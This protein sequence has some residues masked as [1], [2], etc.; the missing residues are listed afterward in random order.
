MDIFVIEIIDADSVHQKLLLEF[1]KKE[2]TN[3]KK[4]N[5][6]CLSYLMVDRIL[7]EFY[8]LED[9]EVIFDNG[10]PILKSGAKHFSISHS[11]D[12]I[13]LAFSESL[14]GVDIEKNIPRDFEKLSERMGFKSQSLDEFYTDWTTYEAQF[15]L[16]A[17]PQS[18]KTYKFGDYTLTVASSNPDEDFEI[19]IQSGQYFPLQ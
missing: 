10:K 5:E 12:F 13:A 1:K 11:G 8:K 19:Y 7:R 14:C 3:P 16:G 9:R 17:T 2:I 6:H 18:G 15:K 4:L